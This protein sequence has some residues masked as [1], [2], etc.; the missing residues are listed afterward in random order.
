[1]YAIRSYYDHTVWRRGRRHTR[2]HGGIQGCHCSMPGSWRWSRGGSPG[3]F[4]SGPIHLVN[5]VALHLS[6]EAE[7]IFSDRFEDY[8]PPVLVRVGGIELYSYNFV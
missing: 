4:L 5:N 8:L 3:K 7:I 1:M 2:L 6:D